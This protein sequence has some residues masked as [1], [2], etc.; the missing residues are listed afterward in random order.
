MYLMGEINWRFI[1]VLVVICIS[2]IAC[3][4]L[5]GHYNSPVTM[6]N[7]NFTVHALKGSTIWIDDEGH[8]IISGVTL[9]AKDEN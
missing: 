9:E 1:A 8:F 4:V 3:G 7:T 6:T 5:L 2:L